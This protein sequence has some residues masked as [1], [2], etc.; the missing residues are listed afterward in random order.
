[1][2]RPRWQSRHACS[3]Q[4]KAEKGESA[5]SRARGS[6]ECAQAVGAPDLSMFCHQERRAEEQVGCNRVLACYAPLRLGRNCPKT[7][8][9]SWYSL[10]SGSGR[11]QALDTSAK[12]ADWSASG[13]ACPS[14]REPRTPY[15]S[16][17]NFWRAR[18][19]GANAS[20]TCRDSL[21][22]NDLGF[23]AWGLGFRETWNARW[24]DCVRDTRGALEPSGNSQEL[25]E[26][27]Q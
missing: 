16:P 6:T 10:S 18:L 12:H 9:I 11:A 20:V 26:H 25:S 21:S 15:K 23:G 19:P 5:R 8:V 7:S 24:L 2:R 4:E 3:A 17:P 27:S 14:R 13:R 22:K 1:M